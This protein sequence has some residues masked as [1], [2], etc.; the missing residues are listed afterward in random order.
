MYFRRKEQFRDR[1]HRPTAASLCPLESEL[2]HD[3]YESKLRG[4]NW[5]LT[6]RALYAHAGFYVGK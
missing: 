2:V 6:G 5:G 3:K 1:K 4:R